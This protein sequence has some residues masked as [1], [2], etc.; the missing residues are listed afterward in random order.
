MNCLFLKDNRVVNILIFDKENDELANRILT[1][2]GFDD[3]LWSDK[4]VVL[5]SEYKSKKFI[6]PTPEH[7]VAIGVL[8][9]LPLIN[10]ALAE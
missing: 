6:E 1:E 7:L 5:H 10:E 9:E 4:N 3:Y 8:D 2:Q